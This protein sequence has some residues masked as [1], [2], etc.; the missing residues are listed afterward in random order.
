MYIY[1]FFCYFKKYFCNAARGRGHHKRNCAK[2]RIAG[3]REK[4]TRQQRVGKKIMPASR[5]LTNAALALFIK[6]YFSIPWLREYLLN[7]RVQF[8]IV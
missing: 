7:R 1:I 3:N 2:F 4:E 6:H 5:A 8:E